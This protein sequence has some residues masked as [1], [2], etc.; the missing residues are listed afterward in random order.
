MVR[1]M[2]AAVKTCD[3]VVTVNN[4]AVKHSVSLLS[5]VKIGCNIKP[6]TER[7]KKMRIIIQILYILSK[8]LRIYK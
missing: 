3:K 2:I 5:H 4:I 7:A 6:R 1:A 8:T